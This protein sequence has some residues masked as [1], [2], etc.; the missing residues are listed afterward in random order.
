MNNNKYEFNFNEMIEKFNFDDFINRGKIAK[1]N[2]SAVLLITN[3]QYVLSWTENFGMGFHYPALAQLY[4]NIYEDEGHIENSSYGYGKIKN[5]FEEFKLENKVSNCM[6]AKLFY[7]NNGGNMIFYALD[8]LN[9]KNYNTFLNFYNNYNDIIKKIC[10]ENNFK[11]A[12]KDKNINKFVSS[13]S[14]DK[15]LKYLQENLDYNKVINNDNEQ[16][17]GVSTKNI[18]HKHK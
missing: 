6:H 12:F 16:I 3:N 8:S 10:E 7:L 15:L 2:N 1:Y 5:S 18:K 11:I 13:K 17:I 4:K 14:L 9:Y